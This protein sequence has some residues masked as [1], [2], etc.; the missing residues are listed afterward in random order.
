LKILITGISGFIGKN[1]LEYFPDNIEIIGIYNRSSAIKNFVSN[2]ELK[3]IKLYQCDL[4]NEV[5]VKNLFSGIGTFFD[6]CIYL[7]SNV[8]VSLSINDP[9]KDLQLNT[10]SL[11]NTLNYSRHE[12]FVYMSTAGVYDGLSGRVN[13]DS[14]LNPTNP[15]CISKLA[16]EQYV[17]YFR[18]KDRIKNYYILR[19]GGAFGKYS[20]KKFTTELIKDV[21]IKRKKII[22]IYGDGKNIIK[23]M[24]VKDLIYCL[25]RCVNSNIK[26]VSC[27]LGQYSFTVEELVY[28]VARI[29][30]K[31]VKVKFNL[32]N[33]E[34]KYIYFEEDNDFNEIFNHRYEYSFEQGIKEYARYLFNTEKNQK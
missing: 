25:L 17:K 34:Q 21:Y 30:D 23:T 29:F 32:L 3:N 12:K 10:V 7:A 9:V 8:D 14:K 1:C 22:P 19:L 33:K 18:T 28:N 4:T 2:K 6:N 16:A 27:N 13:T 5:Q 15:Y 24:Y 11:I 31:N 20:D 26:D